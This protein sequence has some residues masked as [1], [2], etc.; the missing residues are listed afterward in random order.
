MAGEAAAQHVLGE[1]EADAEFAGLQRLVV[2][3]DAVALVGEAEEGVATAGQG[4]GVLERAPVFRQ[5]SPCTPPRQSGG[6]GEG[7][8][9]VPEGHF[10]LP[11]RLRLRDQGEVG[12][13]AE[14]L[15]LVLLPLL[16]VRRDGGLHLP[17]ERHV[18]ADGDIRRLGQFL[19]HFL[20]R[21]QQ[22]SFTRSDP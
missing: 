15:V 13:P 14:Q 8:E 20:G 3:R 5:P 2:V 19:E 7:V 12:L 17:D 1:R 4:L 9:D 21:L 16:V 18:G 6:S 11:G 22:L 10:E